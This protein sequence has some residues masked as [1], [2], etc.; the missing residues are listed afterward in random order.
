MKK[1]S[2]KSFLKYSLL[3][4]AG[5]FLGK[6]LLRA[7]TPI[8]RAFNGRPGRSIKGDHD[9]VEANGDD[10]YSMTVRAVEAMGGMGRFVRAGDTV[11]VKPN[12]G[13]DRAPQYAAT[14]NPMVVAALV[15]LCYKAGAKRVNVFDNTCNAAQRC[16][17]SSGI[18]AAAES[19]GARVYY[20]DNWNIINAEFEYDSPMDGWP[21]IKD[22]VDCDCF[23]NVPVLKNHSLTGLT[24]SMKNLMGVCLGSRGK[25]H[26]NIGPM[27][28]DLTDFIKPELTVID[29]YRILVG[30][31]PSGG[32]LH[33][34]VDMKKVIVATDPVL[35]DSYASLLA[36]KQPLSVK[37][38]PE[39]AK[40]GL[41]SANVSRADV[42]KIKV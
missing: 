20:P 31:G 13:W 40:R 41:G 28:A 25:M 26:S 42:L 15:E 1:L 33:D 6:D 35:A 16:Y 36:G 27:L 32:N 39:A 8:T 22:A 29:A 9:I 21:I 5:L 14:T 12:I 19:K 4:L 38:I 23:I 24:L 34:V 30:N 2:R 37:P 18:K 17:V 3:G 7:Q 11:V 10:P